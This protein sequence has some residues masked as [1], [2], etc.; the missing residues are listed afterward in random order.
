MFKTWLRAIRW[1]R[2]ANAGG[3]RGGWLV[4]TC[5]VVA[6][7][8]T[9]SEAPKAASMRLL[10]PNTQEPK[11]HLAEQ[12]TAVYFGPQG[13]AT[14]DAVVSVVFSKPLRQLDTTEPMPIPPLTIQ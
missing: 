5:L 13:D 1:A 12:F 3:W 10:K 8:V 14:S 11:A 4:F 7:C 2:R 6:A 9:G